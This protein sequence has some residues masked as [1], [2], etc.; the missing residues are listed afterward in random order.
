MDYAIKYPA[1]VRVA[2]SVL[3]VSCAA[4]FT[5]VASILPLPRRRFFSLWNMAERSMSR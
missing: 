3:L 1:T 2:K 5:A 4:S